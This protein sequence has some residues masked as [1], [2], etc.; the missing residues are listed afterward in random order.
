MNLIAFY[1]ARATATGGRSGGTVSTDD[2]ALVARLELPHELGGDAEK[3]ENA[4][5]PEQLLACAWAASFAD[6]IGF[7]AKQHNNILRE[8]EVTATVTFGQ[9]ENDGFGILAEFAVG[10]PE[11]RATEAEEIIREAR[12]ACP[13]AKAFNAADNLKITVIEN[14]KNEN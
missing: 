2:G 5:N 12:T 9:Y 6:A 8:I 10:L 11:L 1:T 13:Y 3:T 7:V 4:V 14:K